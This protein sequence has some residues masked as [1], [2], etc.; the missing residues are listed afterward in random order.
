MKAFYLI[1]SVVSVQNIGSHPV[2]PD[3]HVVCAFGTCDYQH[4][5]K[6]N[7]CSYFL[8]IFTIIYFLYTHWQDARHCKRI[9]RMRI[10]NAFLID[11]FFYRNCLCTHETWK[12]VNLYNLLMLIIPF[13]LKYM[14]L[15]FL[16]HTC[17]SFECI[18]KI[19]IC[20]FFWIKIYE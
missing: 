3:W 16:T 8:D 7:A 11:Y 2:C 10:L 17:K 18:V 1:F 13:I 19:I 6:Q 12:F 9:I 14:S 5:H 15:D 4:T 20:N